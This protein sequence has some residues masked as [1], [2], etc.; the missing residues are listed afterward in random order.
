MMLQYMDPDDPSDDDSDNPI[1]YF[2]KI[3]QRVVV[4]GIRIFRVLEAKI[5]DFFWF[6]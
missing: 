5:K 6:W 2:K 1:S 4:Q 3:V